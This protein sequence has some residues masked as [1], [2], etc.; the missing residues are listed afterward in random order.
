MI[1]KRKATKS[2]NFQWHTLYPVEKINSDKQKSGFAPFL[3]PKLVK[4]KGHY[5]VAEN[6]IDIVDLEI[7]DKLEPVKNSESNNNSTN[8]TDI[9]KESNGLN[10][11]LLKLAG[12]NLEDY[13][14]ISQE[15]QKNQK[16]LTEE[17]PPP[18]IKD[19][20]SKQ[21]SSIRSDKTRKRSGDHE[22]SSGS[23]LDRK[24]NDAN[25]CDHKILKLAK[26]PSRY[27]ATEKSGNQERF[28]RSKPKS[29][30][31][32]DKTRKRSE[33]HGLSS[34]SELDRKSNDANS[35]DHKILKLARSPIRYDATQKSGN[36][37]RFIRSKSKSHGNENETLRDLKRIERI[38]S[39]S[40]SP[41]KSPCSTING[42]THR[43][44]MKTT[45]RSR[46]KRSKSKSY[47]NENK[48]TKDLKRIKPSRS[49]IKSQ[50]YS[51]RYGTTYIISM[52]TNEESRSKSRSHCIKDKTSKDLKKIKLSRSPIRSHRSTI[53]TKNGTT[54]KISMETTNR[55]KSLITESKVINLDLPESAPE[56]KT[57]VA[58]VKAK[59]SNNLTVEVQGVLFKNDFEF[60]NLPYMIVETRNYF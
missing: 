4:V 34:G 58:L 37:E 12:Y 15:I 22:L 28:I 9:P 60:L 17:E 21:K 35:C 49:P 3:N 5:K 32:S 54:Y 14:K 46:S 40:R 33:D 26:S 52:E 51:T 29:P 6:I 48:T 43:I 42:T 13:D 18:R 10:F 56:T 20:R 30:I 1:N 36:Q 41:I 55:P 31:R 23:E 50:S 7:E 16:K 39:L 38:R 57:L 27:D 2:L 19:E 44:S 45:E 24:N 8:L 11:K 47:D 25:S 59:F 53:S